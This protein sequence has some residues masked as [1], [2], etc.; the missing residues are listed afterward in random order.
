MSLRLPEGMIPLFE[1]IYRVHRALDGAGIPHAFGGAI[2]Y[3]YYG[4]PR[5]TTDIDVNIFVKETDPAPAL[6]ALGDIGIEIDHDRASMLIRRDGQIRLPWETTI[7]DLFFMTFEF[8]ESAST[9]YRVMPYTPTTTLPVLSVE[10]LII[11]KVAFNRGKDWVDITNLLRIQA[12]RLDRAYLD[13][14][15]AGAMGDDERVRRFHALA[16]QYRAW[17]PRQSASS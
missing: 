4:E 9:R 11:C 7:V 12:G 17:E 5:A 1:R 8:L 2:A 3:D 15:L 13:R 14:W 10:D 16:E 6:K